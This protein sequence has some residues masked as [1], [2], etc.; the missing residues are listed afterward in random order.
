MPPC[1]LLLV[2]WFLLFLPIPA[3]GFLYCF[4]LSVA[5][6]AQ[7]SFLLVLHCSRNNTCICY[8]QLPLYFISRPSSPHTSSSLV[9]GVKSLLIASPTRIFSTGRTFIFVHLVLLIDCL[10]LATKHTLYRSLHATSVYFY[11]SDMWTTGNGR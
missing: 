11:S 8:V 1:L 3:F 7:I 4:F 6:I 9:L 10:V 5:A 2:S